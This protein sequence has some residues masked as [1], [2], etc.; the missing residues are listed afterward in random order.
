MTREGFFSLILC[1]P[2]K[3]QYNSADNIFTDSDKIILE[4]EKK[5]G[6]KHREVSS[7][8]IHTCSVRDWGDQSRAVISVMSVTVVRFSHT[9][10]PATRRWRDWGPFT[11]AHFVEDYLYVPIFMA[12]PAFYQRKER[13]PSASALRFST[14]T[15]V[16]GGKARLKLTRASLVSNIFQ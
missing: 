1:V 2:G 13:K 8:P 16:P 12:D 15:S 14:T 6:R 7:P 3:P 9:G 5:S 4:T 10:S 11:F